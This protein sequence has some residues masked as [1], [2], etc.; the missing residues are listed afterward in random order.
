MNSACFLVCNGT[1]N[2]TLRPDSCLCDACYRDALRGQGKPRWVGLSKYLIYKH[3]FICCHGSNDCSCECISE[4]GPT[5]HFDSD[6]E[7]EAW[8]HYFKCNNTLKN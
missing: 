7:L 1:H 2:I 6:N 8:L 3:C 4:W 5:Q